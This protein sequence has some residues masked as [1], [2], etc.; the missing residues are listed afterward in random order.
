MRGA[1]ILLF[2]HTYTLSFTA[3][4]PSHTRNIG[5]FNPAFVTTLHAKK[6]S[7]KGRLPPVAKPPMN[8]EIK[9]DSLRVVTQNPKGKDEP[10]GVMTK[11]EALAKAKEL[12]DLDLI[13]INPNADPPVCKI[14]DYSKYR[15][16]KEKKAKEI[17]KNSSV[18]G[19]KEIKMSYNIGKGDYEVRLKKAEKFINNGN[20]VKCTIMFKGREVTHDKLGFEVLNKLADDLNNICL[21]ENKPKREGRSLSCFISPKP[22]VMKA[23]NDKKRKEERMKKK[24]KEQSWKELEEKLAA[25][26]AA[27]SAANILKEDDDSDD[28]TEEKSLDDLLGGD[29]LMDDLFG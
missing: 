15:Y 18:S 23:I 8:S 21:M 22:D 5:T 7:T 24:E 1:T 4:I 19:M 12:G 3:L 16:Q 6:Y 2:F 13:L 17:K 25:K 9:Y 11:D 28:G 26:N 10:I 27:S 20:R 29:S 14:V